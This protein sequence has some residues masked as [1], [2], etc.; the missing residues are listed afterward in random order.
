MIITKLKV[1]D[2]RRFDDFE[3]ELSPGMTVVCG[4]NEAGKSTIQQALITGFYEKPTATGKAVRELAR[5][6]TG[7][8]FAI[9]IEFEVDGVAWRLTKDFQTKKSLLERIGAESGT[10]IDDID[11]IQARI[12]QW[13]GCPSREFFLSTACVAHDDLA[14]VDRDADQ[15]AQQLQR[16]ISGGEQTSAPQAVKAL[17]EAIGKLK[18]GGRGTAKDLGPGTIKH[19]A[20]LVEKDEELLAR[21][22]FEVGVQTGRAEELAAAQKERDRL[23]EEIAAL[24]RTVGDAD[25]LVK[26]EEEI[27]GL[28]ETYRKSHRAAE[29]AHG[30]EE[31][32]VTVEALKVFGDNA[33]L[34][35]RLPALAAAAEGSAKV[36][37]QAGMAMQ[38]AALAPPSVSD[39]SGSALTWL[40]AAA[41]ALGALVA[42]VFARWGWVVA[43]LGALAA[44]AGVAISAAARARSRRKSTELAQAWTAEAQRKGQEAQ[45]ELGQALSAL[46]ATDVEMAQKRLSEFNEAQRRLEAEK[47]RLAELLAGGSVEGVEAAAKGQALLLEQKKDARDALQER[48]PT[49]DEVRL[50]RARVAEAKRQLV[51]TQGRIDRRTGALDAGGVDPDSVVA[52]EERLATARERLQ[53]LERRLRIY[54]RTAAAIEAAQQ[55]TMTTITPRLASDIGGYVSLITDGRYTDAQVDEKTLRITAIAPETGERAAVDRDLSRGTRDQFY[56]AARVGLVKLV[57]GDARPPLILDEPLVGFDEDRSTRTWKLLADIAEEYQVLVLSCRRDFPAGPT[58]ELA[59]PAS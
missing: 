14:G 21:V 16:R 33:G 11:E 17:D 52:I 45:I 22:S 18:K 47:G 42:L 39:R 15:L 48:L 10:A 27:A 7:E 3:L 41:A 2:F 25:R 34:V 35:A 56:L 4:P 54:E 50:T 49:A 58:V 20:D 5:W 26:L 57:C 51:E 31:S 19:W 6:G 28:Q 1:R 29:L 44:V 46:G 53:I 9:E 24:E 55:E 36:S 43:G 38:A 32:A 40:G 59:G 37:I 23:T 13:L 30:I 12:R 8:G